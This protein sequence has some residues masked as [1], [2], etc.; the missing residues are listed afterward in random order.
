MGRALKD[1][2]NNVAL[3]DGDQLRAGL[4]KDLGFTRA[5]RVENVCRMAYVAAL[6]PL[7]V[8][9]MAT[10]APYKE[11]RDYCREI[12]IRN[13][14]PNTRFLTVYLSTPLSVC[15]DRDV[16]GLY[17]LAR[18]GTIQ[19]FTGIDDPYEVPEPTEYDLVLDTGALSLNECVTQILELI[20]SSNKWVDRIS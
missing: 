9:I 6:M 14:G 19:H 8:V 5:D 1:C 4:C 11:A 18:L 20:E 10:I 3:L 13:S 15:E 7:D 2:L 17:H 16:K 12:C